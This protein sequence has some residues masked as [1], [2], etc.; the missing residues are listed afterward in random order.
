MAKEFKTRAIQKNDTSANWAKAVNF[1]PLK[2]ELILYTDL[3]KIKIGDGVTVVGDLPFSDDDK[4]SKFGDTMGGSLT[5]SENKSTNFVSAPTGK[6]NSINTA[7]GFSLSILAAETSFP[8]QS[9]IRLGDTRLHDSFG[10]L[11]VFN[12]QN[13][14]IIIRGVKTPSTSS[15]A[16]NKG[17]VD[18]KIPTGTSTQ[19]VG[20]NENGQMAA[21]DPADEDE[22]L[23]DIAEWGILT[24]VAEGEAI[25]IETTGIII[26]I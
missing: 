10:T 15:D 17:Y 24:P 19:Y 16:V 20:F 14:D 26:T 2:G 11:E 9:T 3:N 22:A 7:S 12:K 18:E 21:V 4:V 5:I 13:N 6:F 25:L 1:V 23:S 8:S